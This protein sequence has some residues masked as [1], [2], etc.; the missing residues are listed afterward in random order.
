MKVGGESVLFII[1]VAEQ[2]CENGTV[3]RA[4]PVCIVRSAA[5]G[6]NVSSEM[7]QCEIGKQGTH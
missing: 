2:L 3:G 5:P 1:P 6:W 7:E 4:F